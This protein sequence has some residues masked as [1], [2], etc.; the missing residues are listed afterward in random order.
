MP[1]TATPADDP[2]K[3]LVAE[4]D[5]LRD[6]DRAHLDANAILAGRVAEAETR[7][8]AAA[9]HSK[10]VWE[11][12]RLMEAAALRY[13]RELEAYVNP[14]KRPAAEP[15]TGP[16]VGSVWRHR[17]TGTKYVVLHVGMIE[18]G[19]V[20]CVVY[21]LHMEPGVVWVRPVTEFVDG[22]FENLDGEPE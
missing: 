5:Y 2:V 14:P 18:S 7:A 11:R 22:R 12:Y 4:L 9:D 21:R 19:L 1:E 3:L 8:T 20:P 6:R 17:K 13:K 16:P 15:P 10:H